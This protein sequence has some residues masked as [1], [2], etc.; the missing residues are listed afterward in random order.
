MSEADDGNTSAV[1]QRLGL[2]VGYLGNVT[3]L[4]V[5]PN[6]VHF[7]WFDDNGDKKMTFINYVS[8]VS[9][10]RI[11]K[12]DSIWFHCN[13]L[14][15]GQ[16]WERLWKEVKSRRIP[17]CLIFESA[18]LNQFLANRTACTAWIGYWSILLSVCPSVC[19][20][21]YIVALKSVY[22]A[23]ILKPHS[24]CTARAT[25]FAERIIYQYLEQ[26]TTR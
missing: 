21:V 2:P 26:L 13:H 16:W 10:Y 25:F 3:S 7:I 5:V 9:A 8:I 4:A 11:Q 23:K 18:E 22:R 12:P 6:I 14:P 15:T 24:C 20:A 17:K 19:N 1:L